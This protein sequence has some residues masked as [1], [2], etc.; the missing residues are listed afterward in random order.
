MASAVIG[1]K[2]YVIG[3]INKQYQVRSSVFVYDPRRNRWSEKEGV[4]VFTA[5]EKVA[6]G[7]AGVSE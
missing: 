1:G 3:G 7:N 5:P 6:K 4:P 2:L